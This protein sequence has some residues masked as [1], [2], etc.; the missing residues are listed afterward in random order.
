MEVTEESILHA[1]NNRLLP[2]KLP[3]VELLIN[4]FSP[5]ELSSNIICFGVKSAIEGTPV[6]SIKTL[7][8]L[9]QNK[10]DPNSTV[11][12]IDVTTQQLHEDTPLAI[13]IRDLSPFRGN[14]QLKIINLLLNNKADPNQYRSPLGESCLHL[15]AKR[16]VASGVI[17]KLFEANAN[18]TLSISRQSPIHIFMENNHSLHFSKLELLLKHCKKELDTKDEYGNTALLAFFRTRDS[19]PRFIT[20]PMVK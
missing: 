4:H 7:E 16:P 19:W 11:R 1:I 20:P 15:A 12:E 14:M 3:V 10:G 13:A 9:L 17:E 18:V 8:L 6:D 2:R 5:N